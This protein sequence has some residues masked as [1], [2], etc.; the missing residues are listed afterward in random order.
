MSTQVG[1]VYEDA[2]ETFEDA[3]NVDDEDVYVCISIKGRGSTRYGEPKVRID[4]EDK[5]WS[6]A[7]LDDV[8]VPERDR[9]AELDKAI[10]E[11]LDRWGWLAVPCDMV[12]DFRWVHGVE[13]LAK[14]AVEHSAYERRFDDGD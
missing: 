12:H 5:V 4:D 1:K 2:L 8:M 3:A 10:A 9:T 14:A 7:Q 6:M 13:P 11:G